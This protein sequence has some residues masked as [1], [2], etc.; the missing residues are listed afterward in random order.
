ML[1]KALGLDYE[2]KIQRP[3]AV[4]QEEQHFLGR[5]TSKRTPGT[6]KAVQLKTVA[7]KK[8]ARTLSVPLQLQHHPSLHLSAGGRTST[9]I[10]N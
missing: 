2:P 10:T 8:C 9:A 6:S 7:S 4:A 1:R 3:R 5:H